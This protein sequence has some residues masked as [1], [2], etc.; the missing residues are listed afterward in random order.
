MKISEILDINNSRADLVDMIKLS[1][2]P[3]IDKFI[4][5]ILFMSDNFNVPI[6]FLNTEIVSELLTETLRMKQ[7]LAD[8]FDNTSRWIIKIN[9]IL[10]YLANQ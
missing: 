3:K 8:H 7:T 9:K 1:S 4:D 2:L 6:E 10:S 5:G